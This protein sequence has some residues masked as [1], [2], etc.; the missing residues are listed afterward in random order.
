VP[1]LVLEEHRPT[2][3]DLLRPRLARLPRWARFALAGVVGLL[4]LVVAWRILAGGEGG[5]HYVHRTPVVFNFHYGGDIHRVAPR[6][7]EIVR[8]ER[9][10]RGLF[11]DSFAV[12]P[13]SLPPYRGNVSGLLPAY[14]EREIAAL[15]RRVPEFELLKEA[16]S[17]VNQVPGYE[18]QFRGRMGKRRLFGRLVLLP[19]P[20]AGED[21]ANPTGELN[22][23]RARHGARILMLATPASGVVRVRD[24]G[25]HGPLKTAFRSFR[26]GTQGP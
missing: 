25:A 8:L 6:G 11:L 26:F 15:R 13:L 19:A 4:V 1:G 18:V 20:A 3:A 12:E 21:V 23:D 9:D 24:V 2:L 7:A 16:K 10:R 17:R 14:A 5:T 22:N